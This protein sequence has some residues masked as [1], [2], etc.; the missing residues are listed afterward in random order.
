MKVI[1][2]LW[3]LLLGG[4]ASGGMGTM[5]G[6]MRSWEGA[7]VGQ[8]IAQWGYPHAER[9]IAGRQ[10]LVWGRDVQL[11]MPAT[12]TTSSTV[13]KIGS[14]AY[15]TSTTN[16]AGGG[17]SNWSCTRTLEIKDDKVVSWQWEGNNCPFA[18]M[19]PYSNWRRK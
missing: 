7:T 13:N 4:C 3:A 12:A 18:E 10:L 15:V 11:T 17:T 9:V 6:I 1:F 8:V 14:T 5:D 16:Y 2:T 19:G